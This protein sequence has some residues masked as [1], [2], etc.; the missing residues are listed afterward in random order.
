MAQRPLDL[1]K[2]NQIYELFEAGSMISEIV[3]KVG[4]NRESVRKYLLKRYTPKQKRAIVRKNVRWP[5]G[6][7]SPNWKGGR[8]ITKDGYVV[9]WL[10]RR[11]KIL[12][13]R[14]V[15]EKHLGRKLKRSEV[16]HHINGNNADNRIKN[17]QLTN[18]AEEI[19][20]H[21]VAEQRKK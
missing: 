17:L 1:R 16:I 20:R 19:K 11:E 5:T 2:V 4:T 3:T 18:F 6:Q 8:E 12:E 15:M 13:H 9:L 14:L 7:H 21:K 10:S